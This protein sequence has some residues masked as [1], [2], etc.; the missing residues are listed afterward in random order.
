MF[1]IKAEICRSVGVNTVVLILN[2]YIGRFLYEIMITV[3]GHEQNKTSLFDETK[4]N[5][6]CKCSCFFTNSSMY[7]T[8]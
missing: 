3:Q 2:V 4:L 8:Y 5:F 7:T 6:C 1:H